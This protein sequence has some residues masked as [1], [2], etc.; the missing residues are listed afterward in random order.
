MQPK[1]EVGWH[2]RVIQFELA[3]GR[4]RIRSLNQAVKLVSPP[5]R[6]RLPLDPEY[7]PECWANQNP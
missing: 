1:A 4:V 3:V 2:L 5:R 6:E 7:G